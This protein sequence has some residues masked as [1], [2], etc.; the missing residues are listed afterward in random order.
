MDYSP[1]LGVVTA[2]FEVIVAGW[3]LNSL[4][5]SPGE[6]R[7]VWTTSAI[8]VLLAGYQVAEVAICANVAGAGFLPR[9]AFIIVTWL[10][11]LG[12]LLIAQL[13]RP[14]SRT[15]YTSAYGLLAAAAGIVAWI[16]IDGSFATASVCNAV[17]AR[18]AHVMPR[19]LVYAWFYWLG[20]LGMAAFSGHGAMI[21]Q[22]ERRKRQLTLLCGGTLAFT[23]P[24]IALSWVVP[25]TRGALPSILCHFALLLA[26]C[27]A[28]LLV[29]ERRE[30]EET[31]EP[32]LAEAR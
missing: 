32:V 15:S 19:F 14:R 18:Y 10:P 30:T 27:L 9:L 29:L 24:S 28:R 16:V 7:I 12:L 11:P 20:L 8:L 4:R 21:C 2:A 1:I 25:T 31:D 23:I 5:R 3:A 6:R 17:Y 22:D 13:R 26:V